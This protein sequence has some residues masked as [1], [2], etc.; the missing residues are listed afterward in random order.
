MRRREA[1]QALRK[2]EAQ[3][4]N[5]MNIAHIGYWEYDLIDNTFIFNDQFYSV[6]HTSA[7]QVGGYKIS[8]EQYAQIFLYPEDAQYLYKNMQELRSGIDVLE[9]IR[10]IHRIKFGDGQTGYISVTFLIDK[11]D[12]KSRVTKIYGANQDITERIAIEENQA[13]AAQPFRE[14]RQPWPMP[15]KEDL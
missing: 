12:K 4:S 1:E 3:L 15:H 2:S 9:N 8:L 14:H 5:A 10:G 11:K 6:Y 7:E 13:H